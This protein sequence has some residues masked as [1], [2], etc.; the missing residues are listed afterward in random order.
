[1]VFNEFEGD[2]GTGNHVYLIWNIETFVSEL[3]IEICAIESLL[4]E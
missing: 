3:L 2:E 1:M 4:T